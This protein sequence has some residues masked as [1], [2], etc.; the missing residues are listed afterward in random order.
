MFHVASAFIPSGRRTHLLLILSNPFRKL[1]KQ[2]STQSRKLRYDL[3]VSEILG[4]KL[5]TIKSRVKEL[6][7]ANLQSDGGE[8]RVRRIVLRRA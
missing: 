4:H 6:E 2:A 8:R 5:V 3:M 7:R 1:L